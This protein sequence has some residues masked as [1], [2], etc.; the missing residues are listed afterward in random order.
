MS[1]RR[2]SS[3]R[4]FGGCR[5]RLKS[6]HRPKWPAIGRRSQGKPNM[7]ELKAPQRLPVLAIVFA[8]VDR[9]DLTR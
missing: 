4:I 6:V 3:C 8:R 1:Q 7:E 5:K 9:R 2:G